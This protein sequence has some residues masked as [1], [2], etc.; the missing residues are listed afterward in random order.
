M[1]HSRGVGMI[2]KMNFRLG[3]FTRTPSYVGKTTQQLDNPANLTSIVPKV[4][5]QNTPNSIHTKYSQKLF[6]LN[7]DATEK[8]R[9]KENV[10]SG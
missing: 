8:W 6:W 3:K 4:F 10:W 2:L 5:W 1:L 9:T 7:V